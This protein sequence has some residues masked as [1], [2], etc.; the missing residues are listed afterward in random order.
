MS[1]IVAKL[2]FPLTT[3]CSQITHYR[4]RSH[5]NILFELWDMH[6]KLPIIAANDHISG[7]FSDDI[8]MIDLSGSS[9]YFTAN[10]KWCRQS[11]CL[12]FMTNN[13][14]VVL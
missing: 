14:A 4:A 11:Y 2:V 9:A 1:E 13:Y 6:T 8:V 3:S 5:K 10:T 12:T 7:L